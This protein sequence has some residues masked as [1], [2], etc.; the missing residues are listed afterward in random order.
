MEILP[1]LENLPPGTSL[2]AAILVATFTKE[3]TEASDWRSELRGLFTKPFDFSKIKSV[4]PKF[5]V[6]HSDDDPICPIE[7]AK[8]VCAELG[9]EFINL[10]QHQHFSVSRSGP[11][12]KKFPELLQIIEQRVL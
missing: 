6:I 5:I 9:G 7:Q 10:P 4:C 2:K 12:F 1:L 11:R 3:L 8:E